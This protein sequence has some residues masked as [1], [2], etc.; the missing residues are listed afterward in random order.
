MDKL[1]ILSL[2]SDLKRIVHSIQRNSG[3]NATRFNKE[4]QKWL[5][6]AM[7]TDNQKIVKL[8]DKVEKLLK[9]KDDLKKAEECLMYAVLLQNRALYQKN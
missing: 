9:T 8:L 6:E 7:K 4:A 1:A 5:R 3:S 2:A